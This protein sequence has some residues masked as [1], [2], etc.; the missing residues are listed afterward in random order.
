MGICGRYPEEFHEDQGA[1][2]LGGGRG[3]LAGTGRFR[4]K[5]LLRTEG[6]WVSFSGA[7]YDSGGWR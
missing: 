4:K 2:R 3:Q 1:L 7:D 5:V 6:T